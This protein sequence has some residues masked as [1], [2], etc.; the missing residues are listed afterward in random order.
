VV[1]SRAAIEAAF[2]SVDRVTLAGSMTP[3]VIRSWYTPVAALKPEPLLPGPNLLNDDAAFEAGVEGDLP[4]RLLHRAPHDQ[5]TGLLVVGPTTHLVHGLLGSEEGDTPSGD[6]ALLDGGA[7]RLDGVLDAV[8]LLLELDLGGRS[9]LDHDDTAGQLGETLLELLAVPVGVGVVDLTLDLLDPRLDVGLGS[10]TVDDGRES[11]STT[12]LRARPSSSR[13]TFSSL[14]PTS[15]EIT[16]PPVRMA[17]S[18][19]MALRRSPKPGALTAT[20]WKS[21]R[22]LLTT[23]VARA[24]PSTSSEMTSSG[25]PWVHH[26]LQHRDQVVDR[27]DLL[28]G[29]EDE[30]ILEDGLL[31]VGVRDEVG[32]EQSLVELH[33]LGELQLETEGLAFLDRDH[34]VLADPVHGVGDDLADR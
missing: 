33:A 18:W 6:H 25:L 29:D 19:S 21:P 3:A 30:R 23:R 28:V 11:L 31:P 26:L 27:A 22:I 20:D 7:S 24:S 17:M 13:V 16:V 15:S 10:A 14:R 1:S 34:A 9:D 8:L 5:A 2:C 32:G 4:K 12:T